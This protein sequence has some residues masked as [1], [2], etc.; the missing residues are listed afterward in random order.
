MVFLL[1]SWQCE[2]ECGSLIQHGLA[3]DPTAMTVNDALHCCQTDAGPLELFLGV[4]ALKDAKELPGVLHLE[5]YPVI[6]DTMSRDYM[7]LKILH[8]PDS[9]T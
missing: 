6:R 2:I 5:A 1:K 9:S 8:K 3:P 7:C 4:Q